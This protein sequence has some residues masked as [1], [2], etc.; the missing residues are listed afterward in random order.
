[1]SILTQNIDKHPYTGYRNVVGK[2][3]LSTDPC[4]D[5]YFNK[6]PDWDQVT[7]VTR[8][9]VYDVIGTKGFGD[10]ED[11]IFIDDHGKT[12]VLGSYFFEEVT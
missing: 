8:G 7:G 10:A 2:L 6:T 11:V 4:L 1:M 3:R 9:K 12:Q 5:N